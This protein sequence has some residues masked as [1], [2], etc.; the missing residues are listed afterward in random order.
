MAR[1]KAN[2]AASISSRT[3]SRRLQHEPQFAQDP[4][5]RADTYMEKVVV[6]GPSPESSEALV[7]PK[8]SKALRP[9]L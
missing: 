8:A 5:S 6:G 4:E 9:Q 3:W 2:M 1:T 7:A